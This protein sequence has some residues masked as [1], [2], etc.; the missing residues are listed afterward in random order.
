[1]SY[2]F[3]YSLQSLS[4]ILFWLFRAWRYLSPS[5]RTHWTMRSSPFEQVRWYSSEILR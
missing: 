4:Q 5:C 3:L 1:M 2:I